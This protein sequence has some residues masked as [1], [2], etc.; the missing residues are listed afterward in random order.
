MN[1]FVYVG[2]E[3]GLFRHALNWKRYLAE[4]I[5]PY[6]SGR[7]LEVGA[8]TGTNTVYLCD[9][10]YVEWVCLEPDSELAKK[11]SHLVSA[12]QLPSICSVLEGTTSNLPANSKFD[13]ILYIDVLEHIENDSEELQ[14]AAN[15]LAVGG[16]LIVLS[17]AHSWLYTPFDS[18]VG[19]Y[20][21]Y[22][23][24]MIKKM[25]PP[26]LQMKRLL[27]VDSVGILASLG[28]RLLLSQP[29]PKASQIRLWDN[30]MVP[31]SRVLDF[32]FGYRIGKSIFAVM[33]YTR[34]K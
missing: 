11:L 33:S 3:L 10:T 25:A 31:L 24:T 13:S 2:K 21:R 32:V 18:A 20:R 8:G 6:L 12:R 1:D 15:N 30:Y 28:N 16:N 4:L 22:N 26:M 29:I 17:P 14:R 34:A 7:I 27:Y 23:K 5:G 19:H 9:D